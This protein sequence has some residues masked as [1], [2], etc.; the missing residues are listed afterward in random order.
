MDFALSSPPVALGSAFTIGALSGI[1]P[2]GMA[3]ALA[4]AIGF[5]EPLPLAA[6]M[7]LLFTLGHVAAKLPWYWLG[8]H[9]DR[10]QWPRGQRWIARTREMLARRPQYGL[11]LLVISALS[12]VP[13]FHLAS[14][15]AGLVRVPV[16]PFVL[17]CLAG[18]LVRFGMLALATVLVRAL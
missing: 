5:V 17:L 9:A 7:W 4:L 12:S 14:I 8:A 16:L 13:P 1:V 2:S 18:R 3:E 10:V 11:G 15:A 6:G